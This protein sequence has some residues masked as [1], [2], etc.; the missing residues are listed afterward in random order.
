MRSISLT[1]HDALCLRVIEVHLGQTWLQCERADPE[2]S[3]LDLISNHVDPGK[4]KLPK[5]H[6]HGLRAPRSLCLAHAGL[7]Q[8]LALVGVARSQRGVGRCRIRIRLARPTPWPLGGRWGRHRVARVSDYRHAYASLAYSN[9]E[10]ITASVKNIRNKSCIGFLMRR[11]LFWLTTDARCDEVRMAGRKAA[12]VAPRGLGCGD[13]P[14]RGRTAH[15]FSLPSSNVPHAHHSS[16]SAYMRPPCNQTRVQVV[17]WCGV[18]G[19][20][21]L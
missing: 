6:S 7:P 8:L 11:T 2:S 19:V 17:A 18:H 4:I 21:R 10:K 1:F 13:R 12:T 3:M 9:R 16:L 15:E 5:S 14:V 20:T